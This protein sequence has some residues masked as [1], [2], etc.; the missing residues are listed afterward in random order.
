MSRWMHEM[1]PVRH[2]LGCGRVALRILAI[3][4]TM[5]TI[6]AAGPPAAFAATARSTISWGYGQDAIVPITGTTTGGSYTLGP[7]NVRIID[8]PTGINVTTPAQQFRYAF[9]NTDTLGPLT[10][11]R[12]S[13]PL[14]NTTTVTAQADMTIGPKPNGFVIGTPIPYSL[15]LTAKSNTDPFSPDG[16]ATASGK[17]PQFIDT[18]GV[19]GGTLS[20]G[21][22]SSVFGTRPGI[23]IADAT[24]EL[25]A[26]G[27][28]DPIASLDIASGNGHVNATVHFNSDPRLSFFEPGVLDSMNQPIPITDT[29]VKNILESDP[30]LGTADGTLTTLDL[31]TYRYDMSGVTLTADAALGSAG[32]ASAFSPG[33][34]VPEPGT[35]AMML[36]GLALLG[37]V[38]RRGIQE[39][40]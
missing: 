24:F 39:T 26:F 12:A 5:C 4:V 19:F 3:I 14:S 11:S 17:D 33:A 16:Y 21:P 6:M 30:Y 37:S 22:G 7:L 28:S 40:A 23:D 1:M 25:T 8:V 2:A 38:A 29:A 32:V 15:T 31:F 13:G 36:A 9:N 34:P 10:R 27:L 18:A 20:I 35:Y